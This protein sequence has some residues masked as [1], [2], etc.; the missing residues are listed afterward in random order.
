MEP[1]RELSNLEFIIDIELHLI[2]V[3]YF[4]QFKSANFE[5]QA[6]SFPLASEHTLVLKIQASRGLFKTRYS[7]YKHRMYSM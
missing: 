1:R 2:V 4:W 3:I 6:Y 5:V 7:T